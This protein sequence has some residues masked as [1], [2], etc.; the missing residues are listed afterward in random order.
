MDTAN[1][2]E[3][4][5]DIPLRFEAVLPG[6]VL[7]VSELLALAE[8]SVLKTARQAGETLEI[9][10]GEA[11]IGFAELADCGPRRGVRMV[12]FGAESR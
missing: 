1:D 11:L 2:F 4:L 12:R 8:G 5:L 7:R 10:A 6:P 3:H 9:L